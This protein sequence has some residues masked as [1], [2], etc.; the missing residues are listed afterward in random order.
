MEGDGGFDTWVLVTSGW[1]SLAVVIV[2]SIATEPPFPGAAPLP[3]TRRTRTRM[4]LERRRSGMDTAAI[5]MMIV[6]LLTVWGGMGAVITHLLRHPDEPADPWRSQTDRLP[7]DFRRFPRP[8][9]ARHRP[10]WA[11]LHRLLLAGDHAGHRPCRGGRH[12]A[13]EVPG[14]SSDDAFSATMWAVLIGIVG[15]RIYR[16]AELP[17]CLLRRRRRRPG[18]LPDLGGRPGHHRRACGGRLSGKCRSSAAAAASSSAPSPTRSSP[19]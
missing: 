13:V 7:D 4:K 9:P 2:A 19:V 12:P 3:C 11:L 6:A 10:S 15:A 14:G 17:R 18:H 8:A 1:G 16:R 5:V